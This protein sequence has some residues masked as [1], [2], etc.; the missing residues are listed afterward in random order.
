MRGDVRSPHAPETVTRFVP[1]RLVLVVEQATE[2]IGA[3]GAET[4]GF[5]IRGCNGGG[6]R[7]IVS[8]GFK[9]FVGERQTFAVV[10]DMLEN[11]Q[12]S[13]HRR[14]RVLINQVKIKQLRESGDVSCRAQTDQLL[15][16]IRKTDK[17]E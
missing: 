17:A 5:E 1:H 11:S 9:Q 2:P 6:S 13:K 8:T 14:E 10:S 3:G 16:L 12:V 7:A 4:D 15:A